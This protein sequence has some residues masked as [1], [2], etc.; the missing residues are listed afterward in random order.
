MGHAGKWLAPSK[1]AASIAVTELLALAVTA[2]A[3]LGSVPA[4]AAVDIAGTWRC[5]GAGG[6][7]PQNWLITSGTGSLHGTAELPSGQKFATISGSITGNGVHLV[8]TYLKSFSAGYVAT[9]NGTVS[10]DGN[11]MSGP[12][13][14][15]TGQA[16]TL[17]A[18]RVV[19]T[20][21]PVLGR[22]ADAAPVSGVVL[23]EL[24]G[25][26]GFKRLR[27]GERIPLGSTLD[28]TDGVVS[29]TAAKDRKGHTA[30]GQF[31]AG[32]FRI[33]QSRA[34][35][36]EFTDLKLAGP[37]LTGCGPGRAVDARRRPHRSLWGHSS[38]NYTTVGGSAS[39]TERGTRWLTED[40]CAGT[41]I[42]VVQGS[43][44]VDD[45]PHHRTFVLSAPHSFLA[46]PG[47]GG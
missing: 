41:L 3:L 46:H 33:S 10:P 5:C 39:A 23:L 7:S 1:T 34:A 28:A 47:A 42:R 36:V 2:F 20:P 16:G 25:G 35:G 40:S 9:F 6:A 29:L 17:T 14:S 27:R 38:G 19:S 15:N 22:S 26:K 32:A 30:S 8:L 37:R 18:T 12:W 44:V 11:T 21:P 13:T 24:P 31:Y 43:V 45:F 4:S